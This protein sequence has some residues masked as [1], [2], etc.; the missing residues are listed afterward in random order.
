MFQ[1][2]F[3]R[4]ALIKSFD[5][6][7]MNGNLL[8]SFVVRLS[9]HERNRFVQRFPSY[10]IILLW[11]IL[12]ALSLSVRPLFPVDETRYASVAWEM[13]T[14]NDFLVPYLNGEP[15]SHKP[16]LLFWL[17][18]LSWWLFGVNDWSLRLISPLFSLATLYLSGVVAKRL[19][20]NRN[21][22]AELTPLILLGFFIWIVYSTLT[23][24]DIMLTFFVLSGI[25]SL[26]KLVQSGLTFKHWALLGLTLGGGVLTKGPAIMLHVMPVAILTPW[27]YGRQQ[28]QFRW[29]HWYGGL[30]FAS[31]I[32]A[33]IALCWA[34]PAGIAGGEA[35]RH[36]IF[37]EQ[38]S[39][40]VV[41]SFAHRLPWWWYLQQLPLLL[42]PW[43]LLTP[44]WLGLSKLTLKDSGIRFCAAWALPVFIA[45]SLV[46]GKRIQYLLP[47]IPTLALLLAWAMNEVTGFSWQR[48]H[49]LFMAMLGFLGLALM[50]LPWLNDQYHWRKELSSVSPA[51]GLLLTISAAILATFVAKNALKFVFYICTSSIAALLIVSSGFFEIMYDHYDTTAVASKISELMAEKREIV[52]YGGKYHGQFQFTGRLT[53]PLK[54]LPEFDDLLSFATEHQSCFIIVA[55]KNSAAISDSIIHYHYPFRSRQLGL[56]S[57]QSLL[58]NRGLD[59]VLLPS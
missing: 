9:S 1:Q 54:E 6:L 2:S 4:E 52:F 53:Q 24:F 3:P 50:L 57:C 8:I 16:P 18:Q 35:Y 19:W 23:M 7:R 30:I 46:S 28:T 32:G 55:Y 31:F 58:E 26:L 34:I 36:A 41:N 39:G 59:S 33:F 44:F 25:Y 10:W 12:I 11:A 49:V 37:V 47:L 40:R 51:W 15:Y 38:T 17:I 22:I 21:Q 48:A 43:M 20:P 13:W 5:R 27:W 42:L 14:R 45:F 56:L 29:T